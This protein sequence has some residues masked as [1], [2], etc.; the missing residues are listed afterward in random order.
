MNVVK[1]LHGDC[2]CIN[3][4]IPTI[5]SNTIWLNVIKVIKSLMDRGI[6]LVSFCK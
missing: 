3:G 6:D 2:G 1:A 4:L 5:K